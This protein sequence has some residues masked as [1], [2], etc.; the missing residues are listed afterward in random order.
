MIFHQQ[1]NIGKMK[2]IN[3]RILNVKNRSGIATRIEWL[4]ITVIML[5]CGEPNDTEPSV[6]FLKIYDDARFNASYIPIDII[7]TEDEGF[8]IL[9][10]TRLES[11]DFIGVYILKVDKDGNFVHDIFFPETVV[12]PVA[13]WLPVDDTYYFFAMDVTSLAV[14]LYGVSQGGNLL[15][16]IGVNTTYPLHASVDGSNFILLS[17]DNESKS[18]I[19]ST[20]ASDGSIQSSKDFTIGPGDGIEEPIIDHFTRTGRQYPFLTGRSSDG[21]YYFS[22]FYNYTFSLVFS[23]LNSDD[24]S[25]VV[26]GQRE[27][28]GF[29]ALI[30]LS[31]NVYA[32]SRFNF[33]DNYTLPN[34]S[35]S[36]TGI[37]SI[38]DLEGNPALEWV[39]N[40][41]V[42]IE[43]L[44]IG[45]IEVIVY[46]ST[47]KNS[48]IMLS[49]YSANDGTWLGTDYLG[50]ST[51]YRLISLT[52]SIDNGVAVLGATSVAGRFERICMFKL[53]EE[54]LARIM[55][56]E[57]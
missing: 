49:I 43:K 50:Y 56:S 40:A 33:G 48:Q 7:Q 8:L 21:L 44:I 29:S 45:N 27:E 39:P 25:G 1:N 47:T 14:Q 10:G 16:P 13:D 4:L 42:A 55:G 26:Q 23:D 32:A 57:R 9:S 46:A 53:S 6:N 19:L 12:H 11:S 20:I 24:P 37:S 15:D 52:E 3:K 31:S 17:Y 51:P 35:I 30:P 34:T 5:A 36:S 54:N 41:D 22:G 28:G 18:S 38:T 2:K